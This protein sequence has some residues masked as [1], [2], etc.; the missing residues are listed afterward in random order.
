MPRSTWVPRGQYG[1]SKTHKAG[2]RKK[3]ATFK[4]YRKAPRRKAYPDTVMAIPKA[5]PIGLPPFIWRRLKY[6]DTIILDPGLGSI[7]FHRFR[8][9]SLFDPDRT[10]A[11]HQPMH[12]DQFAL[13]YEHYTV[14]GA[15]IRFTY[16]KGAATASIPAIYG[17]FLDGNT[18]NSYT[19]PEQIMEGAE[20]SSRWLTSTGIENSNRSVTIGWGAKKFFGVDSLSGSQFRT[21]VGT[22]PSEE[23]DFVCWAGDVGG[24]DPTSSSWVVELEYLALF[25]EKSFVAQS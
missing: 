23:A 1:G 2:Y 21:N 15:K 12:F 8:C 16:V 10:G 19:Q 25:S 22:N 17:V 18:T 11:G 4:A 14:Y 6:A 7:A 5:L 20:R 9:N 13:P 3:Y 24:N